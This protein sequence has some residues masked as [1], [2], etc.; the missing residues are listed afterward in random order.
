M[1]IM[2]RRVRGYTRSA[3][4]AK[5]SERK[6]ESFRPAP[7]SEHSGRTRGPGE[8][9]HEV[10]LLRTPPSS[11]RGP[12]RSGV[13]TLFPMPTLPRPG[14]E[15]GLRSGV[16]VDMSLLPPRAVSS[17]W[18]TSIQRTG[19]RTASIAVPQTSRH[20]NYHCICGY[21]CTTAHVLF[22]HFRKW[23]P[24][25]PGSH[26]RSPWPRERFSEGQ[27]QGLNETVVPKGGRAIPIA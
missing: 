14:S 22:K 3:K 6:G 25:E 9:L 10:L 4:A 12:P 5:R 2:P 18:W 19:N 20:L 23:G 7:I 1:R 8:R 27:K 24:G 26:V 17:S 13:P 16:V 21:S 15:D 11:A